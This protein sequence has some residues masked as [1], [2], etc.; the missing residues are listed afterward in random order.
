MAREEPALRER[1]PDG[2]PDQLLGSHSPSHHM[3]QPD[4]AIPGRS[5]RPGRVFFGSSTSSSGRIVPPPEE[6]PA[7]HHWSWSAPPIR[8]GGGR[9]EGRWEGLRVRPRCELDQEEA[10]VWQGAPATGTRSKRIGGRGGWQ[11]DAGR[12][13]GVR[14]GGGGGVT[15]WDRERE[16]GDGTGVQEDGGG[17][18]G[19]G[20]SSRFGNCRSFSRATMWSRM[21]EDRKKQ[22]GEGGCCRGSGGASARVGGWLGYGIV[23]PYPGYKI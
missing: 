3:G 5:G 6:A 10:G 12:R 14:G 18:M 7:V 23:I 2:K 15:E 17:G 21:W 22:S 1:A 20:G 19:W 8:A 11:R 4:L 13:G 16:G 9:G